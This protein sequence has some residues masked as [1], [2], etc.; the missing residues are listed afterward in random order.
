[1]K[2][3]K[4]KAN[5]KLGLLKNLMVVFALGLFISSCSSDDGFEDANGNAAKKYITKIV[6]N[7]EGQIT[8][9]TVNYDSQGKVTSAASGDDTKFFTYGQDGS[10]SKISGNGDNIMTSEV[11]GEIQAAYE[12]GD[13]L[14]FD[15]KGNPTLLELYEEDYQGNQTTRT[16]EIIYDDKPFAFYYTLDAA[17]I[18]DI[19]NDVRLQFY[20][21]PEIMMAKKLLPVNNPIKAIIRDDLNQEV[22]TI[23]V[24]FSYDE[25]NY[26][27][28][29]SV[30]SIDNDGYGESYNLTYEYK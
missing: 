26:P 18:I 20:A 2:L 12:I 21:P 24:G 17:G 27:I 9:S 10:L 3:Y 22:G 15:L 16:A 25:D 30:V 6:T 11:I 5:S 7:G 13:V 8:I 28:T 19:L 14:E 29:A 1:M 23:S 4:K